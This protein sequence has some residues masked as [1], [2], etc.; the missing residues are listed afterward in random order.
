MRPGDKGEN[1]YLGDEIYHTTSFGGTSPSAFLQKV[2][3]SEMGYMAAWDFHQSEGAEGVGGRKG[4]GEEISV[5][6]LKE[7]SVRH[8]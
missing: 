8:P 6:A 1:V 2:V 3:R 4:V 7:R 5:T